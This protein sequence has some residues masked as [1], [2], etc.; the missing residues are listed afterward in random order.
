M[1]A[2]LYWKE[3]HEWYRPVERAVQ[4]LD[5]VLQRGAPPWAPEVR[6]AAL[7]LDDAVR[8]HAADDV[9]LLDLAAALAAASSGQRERLQ[10]VEAQLWQRAEGGC[11]WDSH[12]D[13]L[14]A[15]LGLSWLRDVQPLLRVAEEGGESQAWLDPPAIRWLRDEV[16]HRLAQPWRRRPVGEVGPEPRRHPALAAEHQEH[17]FLPEGRPAPADAPPAMREEELRGRSLALLRFL[18]HALDRNDPIYASL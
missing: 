13:G 7:D 12:D 17:R 6:R 3:T 8:R 15:R 1:G 18:G 9:D 2:D 11:F 10:A 16:A 4:A 14:L 5:R